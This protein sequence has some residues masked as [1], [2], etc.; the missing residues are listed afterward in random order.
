MTKS[1]TRSD[2]L[3]DQLTAAS[4]G[5]P[6]E[7]S[8]ASSSK[9]READATE[10]M[11]RED[12]NYYAPPSQI[13]L[14][15]SDPHWVYRWITEYVNGVYTPQRLNRA[16]AEGYQFVRVDDLPEGFYVDEDHKGDGLARYGGL[17][18]A[19]LPR[20]KAEA[21]RRYY[22]ARSQESLRGANQL[23]GIAGKDT[24]EENRGTRTLDGRAAGEALR[25]MTQSAS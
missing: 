12:L 23:Q 6:T 11:E 4:K 24:V 7:Q 3:R 15:E 20:Q 25:S 19:R 13:K 5:R 1:D 22:Q 2:E 10:N 9:S 16:R 17:V 14:P 18:L 21:R 8:R